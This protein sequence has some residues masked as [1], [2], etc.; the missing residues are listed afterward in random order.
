[1]VGVFRQ[2]HYIKDKITVAS[3]KK[4]M[5]IKFLNELKVLAGI[6]QKRAF[7]ALFS[8]WSPKK[9]KL[10]FIEKVRHKFCLKLK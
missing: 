2:K 9:R 5:K 3:L 7:K 4:L 10:G 6:T 8:L 1:M